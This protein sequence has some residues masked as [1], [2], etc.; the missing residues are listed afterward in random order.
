MTSTK[1]ID[2]PH[3]HIVTLFSPFALSVYP[4]FEHRRLRWI[5]QQIRQR[6]WALFARWILT[7]HDSLALHVRLASKNKYFERL[8]RVSGR[9]PSEWKKE[10][11]SK[12]E[13]GDLHKAF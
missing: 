2:V 4:F 8:G 6:A 11:G 12:R 5:F 13:R 10:N 3:P 9:Q 7:R 1:F